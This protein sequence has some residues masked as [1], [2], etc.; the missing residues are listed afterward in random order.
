MRMMALLA[1]VAISGAIGCSDSRRPPT[2]REAYK[3]VH[4]RAQE[5]QRACDADPACVAKRG[6]DADR[7]A[8]EAQGATSRVAVAIQAKQAAFESGLRIRPGHRAHITGCDERGLAVPVVNIWSHPGSVIGG[9]GLKANRVVGRLSGDGREDRGL[10]CQG[11]VIIVREVRK[12]DDTWYRVESLIGKQSGW[13]K[14]DFIGRKFDT[15]KCA[16]HFS[17]DPIAAAKCRL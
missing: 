13:V 12:T 6:A 8:R 11:A 10:K 5:Q 9:A 2:P 7:R 17:S 14:A 4:A 16:T 3:Q 1:C 15:A